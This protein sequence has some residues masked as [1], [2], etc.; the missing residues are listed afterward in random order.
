MKQIIKSAV[1]GI[2][3][4]LASHNASAAGEWSGIDTISDIYP[5]AT[6]ILVRLNQTS[7]H[8]NSNGCASSTFYILDPTI[9][10]F[11]EQYQLLLTALAADKRVRLY[12]TEC[13]G[14]FPLIRL[15]QIFRS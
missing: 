14:N 8:I 5:T 13:L 11:K 6:N 15:I 3:L 4:L 10:R 7:S 12:S 1:I 2:V 9:D